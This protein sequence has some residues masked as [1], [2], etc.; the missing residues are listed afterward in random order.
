MF[1]FHNPGERCIDALPFFQQLIEDALAAAREVVEALVALLFL[2]PLA[3]QE[4][5]GFQPAEER[6]QCV[7]VDGHAAVGEG[8]AQRIAVMFIAELGKYSQDQASATQLQAEV[9]KKIR[10][11]YCLSHSVY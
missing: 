10:G 9:F 4:A 7:F 8:F 6:I 2:T 11:Q 3:H 1:S 5:L